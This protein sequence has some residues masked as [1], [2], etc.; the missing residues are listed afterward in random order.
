MNLSSIPIL[1]IVTYIPLVGA[2]LIVF[3]VPKEK[4]GTIKALA[5]AFA[6]VDF[7]VS[8]PLWWA[9][10]RGARRL[11]V[12]REGVLDPVARRL[13]PLRHRRDLAHPDPADDARGLDRDLQLVLGDSRTGRRS[14][15]SCSCSSR[16]S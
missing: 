7:V 1:S 3:L 12:R 16:R 11:P 10:E 5:T 13:V 8:M 9:F 2:L 14:T 4:T 6:A 15:T